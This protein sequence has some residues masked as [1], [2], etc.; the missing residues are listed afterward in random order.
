MTAAGQSP[1]PPQH[2]PAGAQLDE[3]SHVL[4]TGPWTAHGM[5]RDGSSPGTI[6]GTGALC[7]P[8]AAGNGAKNEHNNHH[9]RETDQQPGT[10]LKWRS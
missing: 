3:H 5:A 6:Q 7:W 10:G 8:E 1:R 2:G 4:E 9:I